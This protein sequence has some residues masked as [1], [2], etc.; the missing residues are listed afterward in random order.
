MGKVNIL[1]TRNK[2]KIQHIINNLNEPYNKINIVSSAKI[3]GHVRT[4]NYTINTAIANRLNK[5]KVA[6]YSIRRSF[7]ANKHIKINLNSILVK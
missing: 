6:W 1:A 5:G 3:L 2:N 4:T 7:V